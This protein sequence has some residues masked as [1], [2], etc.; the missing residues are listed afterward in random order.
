V[1][2]FGHTEIVTLHNE[3]NAI[4]EKIVHITEAADYA[5]DYRQ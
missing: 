2:K 4:F 3:E 1:N 5:L